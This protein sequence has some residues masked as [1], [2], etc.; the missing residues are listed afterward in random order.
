M[1]QTQAPANFYQQG[2]M[3]DYTP[4]SA[5]YAGD[6][7]VIGSKAYLNPNDIAASAKGALHADGVWQVP[8]DT[9]TFSD[10]DA[11]YWSTTGSPNVGT[12][13]TGAA[14]STASGN[15]LMGA[16]VGAAATGD[17]FV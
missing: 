4:A 2:R 6:I 14:T 16:A 1:A 13:S 11:V 5:V 9:S 8:K 3:R 12:A 10:G 17:Q 15:T 7:I